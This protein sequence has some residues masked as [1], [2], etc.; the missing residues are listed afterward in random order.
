M[1]Y[2]FLIF[3]ISSN[4]SNM[5]VVPMRSMEQCKAAINAMKIAEDKRTWH[6]VSPDID[7]VQCVEVPDGK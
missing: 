4:T 1:A 3:V 5:Q 6:N 2:I 7:S